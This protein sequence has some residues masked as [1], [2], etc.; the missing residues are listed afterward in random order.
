MLALNLLLFTRGVPNSGFRLF[1]GIRIFLRIIRPNTN[2]NS[3]TGWAFWRC[4][5]CSYIYHL[6]IIII[7]TIIIIIII[8]ILIIHLLCQLAASQ[9]EKLQY[10]NTM[11]LANYSCACMLSS[12]DPLPFI[13]LP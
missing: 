5:C 2:T 10:I 6:I 12:D 3:V 9:T 7:I 8:I 1:G 4:T 13:R 11:S